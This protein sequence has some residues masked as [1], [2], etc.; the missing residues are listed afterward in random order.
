MTPADGKE[1]PSRHLATTNKSRCAIDERTTERLNAARSC[2]LEAIPPRDDPTMPS[3]RAVEKQNNLYPRGVAG[4]RK[5]S[6]GPSHKSGRSSLKYGHG[7]IWT[8]HVE[9]GKKQTAAAMSRG[10]GEARSQAAGRKLQKVVVK[11]PS[12][13][14]GGEFICNVH[15]HRATPSASH[16]LLAIFQTPASPGR[17]SKPRSDVRRWPS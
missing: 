6:A 5:R 11:M 17:R 4:S 15:E 1:A 12:P 9:S 14:R 3:R 8:V 16:P 10:W 13:C 2:S 7:N